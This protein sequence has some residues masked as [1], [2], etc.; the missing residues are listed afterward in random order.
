MS[1]HQSISKRGTFL[2]SC[3]ISV[4]DLEIKAISSN[5]NYYGPAVEMHTFL[6]ENNFWFACQEKKN[7][8]NFCPQNLATS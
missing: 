6:E 2:M 5:N 1:C 4:S 8:C 3:Y 7:K